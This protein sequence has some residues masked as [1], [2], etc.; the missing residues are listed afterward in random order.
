MKQEEEQLDREYR[1]LKRRMDQFGKQKAKF[2]AEKDAYQRKHCDLRRRYQAL[3][4]QF[5]QAMA[6]N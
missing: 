4:G 1:E 6:M 2:E 5:R 3:S